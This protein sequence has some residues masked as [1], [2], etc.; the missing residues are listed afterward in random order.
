MR[1]RRWVIIGAGGVVAAG[2]VASAVA[3]GLQGVEVASWLA[4]A[5]SLVVAVSAVVLAPS[6]T[7]ASGPGAVEPPA[8]QK[9]IVVGGDLTGIASTGDNATNS[10]HR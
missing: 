9:S 8:G 10:Q 1:S 2:L 7:S 6:G 5:A 3:F 4:G